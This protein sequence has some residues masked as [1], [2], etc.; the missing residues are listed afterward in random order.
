MGDLLNL[1][2]L[3]MGIALYAML[4][5][6][7]VR[8]GRTRPDG[9]SVDPLL[10]STA[11]L[12]LTWN[13]CALP[14][15]ELLKI[16][17][18]GPFRLFTAL[19]FSALG[20]LPA[21]A[22]HSVLRR[23]RGHLRD[24]LSSTLVVSAYGLGAVAAVLHFRAMALGDALPSPTGMRLLTYA[25]LVLVL[26][27]A[28]LT[29]GQQG[30]RRALWVAAL[31][32]FAVSSLHLS[33]F[34]QG[35]PSWAVELLGHHA[36]LPLAL[37]ILYQDFPFALADLFLKRTLT[38]L[39]VVTIPFLALATLGGFAGDG[40]GAL[41]V[42]EGLRNVL[43]IALWMGTA[44]LYPSL[45][46]LSAWFVDTVVLRRPDY[47]ALRATIAASLGAHDQIDVLLDEVCA[48]VGPALNARVIR[49]TERP[50]AA[51]AHDGRLNTAVGP[52]AA[53][54][55]IAP[56]APIADDE[57]ERAQVD[58]P[59]AEWPG[60]VIEVQGL[61]GGRRLLSDD[62]AFLAAIASLVGRRIDALR[63][64]RERYDRQ[65]REQQM[66]TLATEAELRALRAQINPHFLFNALTTI[67]FLIQTS[68]IRA[69]DTLM[70]LTSLLRAVLRSEGEFTTLGRELDLIEAYLDIESARFEERLRVSVQVPDRLRL[71]RLPSLL[72]QPL[73]ENAVK[74]GIAPERLGGDLLIEA[75]LEPA[76]TRSTLVL[77]VRDSG[78]GASDAALRRGREV[79][80][81]LRNIERRLA[82][83]Y[84][85]QA[86][87]SI[88]SAP[89]G[90]T[91]AVLR[92]P[93]E[94]GEPRDAMTRSAS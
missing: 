10:L 14:V 4:L 17:M 62:R 85:D 76:D 23:D 82:A 32:I 18:S 36:S 11:I 90:G 29:R 31:S 20:L 65:L 71:L 34:H 78:S 43:F 54:A 6:M 46:R 55:A 72:L 9:A 81:G 91:I 35:E 21:V 5:V 68:P 40:V 69:F 19:G 88:R 39:A 25:Y 63:I 93:A 75:R 52:I 89:G 80:V 70:R 33:Q 60:Y 64:T 47:D 37:A 67:G 15:Y 22:V 49:W 13:L 12:G 61:T 42:P 8:T 45:Q 16:G 30:S 77:T 94:M 57:P 74:H 27:L 87:L 44:L 84:G 86:E 92:L 48:R 50:G 56:R 53:I 7:V 26:P 3:S 41:T 83:K 51:A 2:G 73:V 1:I 28:F 79:G 66:A 58:I 59:V 24:R 38:L